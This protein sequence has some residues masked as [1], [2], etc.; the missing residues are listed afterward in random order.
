MRV[1]TSAY[2][3]YKFSGFHKRCKKIKT[4]WSKQNIFIPYEQLKN[5]YGCPVAIHNAIIR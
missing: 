2:L 1:Y 3:N 5:N 4:Q